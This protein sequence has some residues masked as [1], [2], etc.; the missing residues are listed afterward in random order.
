MSVAEGAPSGGADPLSQRELVL[1]R[2]AIELSREAVRHGNHPFGALLAGPDGA[3]LVRAE[4][5]VVTQQ[6]VTGHAETNAV[7]AASRVCA[8]AELAA[9][10]LFSSAEPCAMCAGATYWAGIGRVVYGMDEASLLALTGDH[11]ENPT[12]SLP[13]R[14]VFAAGQRPTVVI[15]PV[16]AEEAAAVHEG[17]WDA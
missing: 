7:R 17:F 11:P 3:V 1:L 5:T 13:S 9:A 6:D 8:S 16:L 12:L 14:R 10:T 4:N 15:G 2:E